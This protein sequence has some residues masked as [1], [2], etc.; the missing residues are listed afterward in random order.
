MIGLTWVLMRSAGTKVEAS[1]P[2][3]SSFGLPQLPESL[4]TVSVA[5]R[6]YDVFASSAQVID[7]ESP[8]QT[9]GTDLVWVRTPDRHE[10]SMTLSGGPFRVRPGHILSTIA[11]LSPD[12]TSANLVGYN[13]T[14]D[15]CE[16][17]AGVYT[18]HATRFLAPWFLVAVAG[19]IPGAFGLGLL[20]HRLGGMSGHPLWV[21]LL[22]LWIMGGFT[23]A[24][25]AAFVAVR[26]KVK[27]EAARTRSFV[28]DYLP[29]YRRLF[30]ESTPALTR[31]FAQI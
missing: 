15:Q 20:F 26:M 17:F 30:L 16:M 24:I 28:N 2:P 5:G 22:A 25:I 18:V 21:S 29:E 31:H 1:P 9:P 10:T 12:G 3:D 6:R 7:R 27:V 23:S 8:S 19:S 14:T 13:H 4:R 11:C